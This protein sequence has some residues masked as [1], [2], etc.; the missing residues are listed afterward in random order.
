MAEQFIELWRVFGWPGE[1]VLDTEEQQIAARLQSCLAEFGALDELLGSM[2]FATAVREFEQ[3]TRETS[4]EP[5]SLP[6][7][8]TIIDSSAVDGLQFD[9][10]WVTDIDE[11]HWPPPA[12][13]DPFIPIALQV[14]AGMP[15]ATA[16]LTREHARRRF[17]AMQSMAANVT[18][19]W[20]HHDKDVEVLPS[21]WLRELG[22]PEDAHTSKVES[23]IT[24]AAAIFLVKPQLETL[25]E[26][27]APALTNMH[28]RGG[29]RIFELQSH[30]PFRAFG[31]LRLDA[32]PLDQVVPSIDARERGTL[33]HA[34][35]ADIWSALGGSEGL[36]ARSDDELVS[37]VRTTL[38]RHATQF[39]DGASLHRARMLQ[40]EQE[41][42][43]ERIVALL[44]LDRQRSAFRVVGRPE[45]QEE[46]TI[47]ALHFAMRLD[48]TD[49]LLDE[50]HRGERVI[51][52]YK[53]GNN[54]STRSWVR[55][56]PEQPQL[57]LYAVTHPQGLAAVA[58]ATVGAKGVAYEGVAR[59]VSVLPGIKA[60]ND[61]YLPAPYTQWSGLLAFWDQVI[62][63]LANDFVSGD[64]RVDPLPTACHHCRLNA[65]C[66]VYE[67]D[68]GLTLQEEG[69]DVP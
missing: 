1:Q 9:A 54:I 62:S 26:K 46:A 18:F 8:I 25:L 2:S 17:V 58:F 35:L 27:S 47:G 57:P 11:S 45:T 23:P 44:N 3:L 66:R 4:F 68:E 29:T 49:E 42:A 63:A 32:K 52:D 31:E 48:R 59:D 67:I 30:C 41:L 51:V 39:L 65:L 40:I 33:I 37:L 13:P 36:H 24:Y 43:A 34:A 19:S 16:Q 21:P 53:T 38:A 61:K 60:F 50:T 10:M 20:A 64:A 28:A 56:R 55:S 22:I 6:A 7:P 69:E 5:R 14:A 15:Q 12:K